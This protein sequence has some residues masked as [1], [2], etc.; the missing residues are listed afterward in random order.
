MRA[1]IWTSNPIAP[2]WQRAGDRSISPS[3]VAWLL[4]SALAD[5]YA[6][7]LL[8]LCNA[9]RCIARRRRVCRSRF[10]RIDWTLGR[11][12]KL[13]DSRLRGALSVS[14]SLLLDIS[15]SA[16]S[17]CLTILNCLI[18]LIFHKRKNKIT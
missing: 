5:Y 15:S 17:Q 14:F 10:S 8:S 1:G 9:L 7:A 12:F 2:N 16:C 18:S 3:L 6:F 11:L 13:I 4:Q